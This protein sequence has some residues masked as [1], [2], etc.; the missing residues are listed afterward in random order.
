MTQNWLVM[1]ETKLIK[2]TN[3]IKFTHVYRD[4]PGS[5]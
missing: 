1:E 2:Q 4:E 5:D 3:N